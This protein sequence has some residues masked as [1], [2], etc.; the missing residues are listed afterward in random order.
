MLLLRQQLVAVLH[1]RLVLLTLGL[2]SQAI[3]TIEALALGAS[4]LS[5]A[6]HSI[7]GVVFIVDENP[8]LIADHRCPLQEPGIIDGL[9]N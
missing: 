5:V 7:E 1:D 8:I 9:G 3:F 4:R 6:G 2:G